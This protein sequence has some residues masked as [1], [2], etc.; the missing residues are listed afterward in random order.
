M[1]DKVMK[2]LR[3]LLDFCIDSGRYGIAI[4]MAQ[5]QNIVNAVYKE[6]KADV[7]ASER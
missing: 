6:E 1:E 5:A 2:E 3:R 4:D 7:P